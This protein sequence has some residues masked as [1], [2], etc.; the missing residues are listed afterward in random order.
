MSRNKKSRK[1]RSL[2][3]STKTMFSNRK[4]SMDS[5]RQTSFSLDSK[6]FTASLRN[7]KK[8]KSS[9]SSFN[10]I[11]GDSRAKFLEVV[12][13]GSGECS[14]NNLQSSTNSNGELSINN[15]V[16]SNNVSV[17]DAGESK[18]HKNSDVSNTLI[19]SHEPQYSLKTIVHP[20]D[21]KK[22][23]DIKLEIP[24]PNE[25][26]PNG[27]CLNDENDRKVSN[28]GIL[29]TFLSAAQHLIPRNLDNTFSD[30]IST[31]FHK[32]GPVLKAPIFNHSS[33]S[34]LQNLDFL[35]STTP[36]VSDTLSLRSQNSINFNSN[37]P[38]YQYEESA[39]Q[40]EFLLSDNHGERTQSLSP[41]IVTD[42]HLSIEDV[43]FKP[44]K[45]QS[46]VLTFGNGDLTLDKLENDKDN[47]ELS[48]NLK[49]T[50][51][52][53]KHISISENMFSKDKCMNMEPKNG[54]NAYISSPEY[55]NEIKPKSS[56]PS[57]VL[58]PTFTAVP[59]APEDSVG[60]TNG[61]RPRGKSLSKNCLPKRSLSPRVRLL[62]NHSLRS[63][64]SG[65]VRNQSND[66]NVL[67]FKDQ[68]VEGISPFEY[69]ANYPPPIKLK[70]ISFASEKKNKEFQQLIRDLGLNIT[71]Q[72]LTEFNCA[73]SKDIL[74][75]GK[76]YISEEHI[77]FYSNIL[78]WV[79]TI[80]VQFKEI[81]Q[82]E[83]KNT[84]GIF[85]NA[86]L[87]HTLHTKYVF[88][89]FIS[90]DS[91][92]E[93]ITN[94]WNQ[95]IST[96]TN[97]ESEDDKYE[98]YN[99]SA[100]EVRSEEKRLSNNIDSGDESDI[101]FSDPEDTDIDSDEMTSGDDLG[102]DGTLSSYSQL[103]D[104]ASLY[105]NYSTLG[106]SIHPPT[107]PNYK[108]SS[109]ERLVGE[110][111]FNAPLGKII[112][113]LFGDDV[114][115]ITGV[116]A[117][118]KNYDISEISSIL[119]PHRREYNYT[120]PISGSI[121]P[122]KTRCFITEILEDY[123]LENYVKVVQISKTPDIP[124]GNSFLVKTIFLLYWAENNHT[125]LKVYASVEWIGKSWIKN[126]I[127][128][129][130]F[131]GVTAT[132]TFLI[133]EVKKQ[134][135]FFKK[136]K[137]AIPEKDVEDKY[138]S[139]LPKMG[140]KEHSPTSNNY[141]NQAGDI[142]ISDD[143]NFLAP[144]G[145]IFQILFG[146]DISYIKQIIE[147]QKNIDISE[148]PKF[149]NNTRSYSYTKPLNGPIGPKQTKCLIVEII[150]KKDIDSCII[151][152]QI[153]RTPDVPSGGAFE[154]QT[155]FFFSWGKNNSTD[156]L[157][158][159]NI[160]W[161][162]KSWIKSAIEKGSTEG[163]RTSIG[164]MVQRIKDIISNANVEKKPSLQKNLKNKQRRSK[165]PNTEE[166]ISPDNKTALQNVLAK[167]FELF[168]F[169]NITLLRGM[170]LSF[171][172]CLL[173]LIFKIS[174]SRDTIT[175]T[176]SGTLLMKGQEYY[177]IP[178]MNTLYKVYEDE[179]QNRPYDNIVT[180]S[181]FNIWD[182][183]DNRGE[184]RNFRK[185]IAGLQHVKQEIEQSILITELQLEDMKKRLNSL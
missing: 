76:M 142:I 181:E 17:N 135:D 78:G 131:D 52:S 5:K 160:N 98:E 47:I 29:S 106:P 74:I 99:D 185:N 134:L 45:C 3:E 66:D 182:W 109:Q 72:L 105:P 81:V 108:P 49:V 13:D 37:I 44:L 107:S 24:I 25:G 32:N 148:I 167:G 16:L 140:P 21:S 175:I 36:N 115:F 9:D 97:E 116:I 63:A 157:V 101:D 117:A 165:I 159:T 38:R 158:V 153:T 166:S 145:T 177:F 46:S 136:P 80:T 7:K 54:D 11:F 141:E 8:G 35:L 67:K 178:S 42:S 15:M 173:I 30:N 172:I 31:T 171:C 86:I 183:I 126:V 18:T 91:V 152:K 92:F 103:T 28:T 82:I 127:E 41:H 88:A 83:K 114:S 84:A 70:N 102:N 124:S 104:K 23:K 129:G 6:S 61:K 163:Q 147:S 68:S 22:N 161:S 40:P 138:I 85:P 73:L 53:D 71:G 2:S 20:G 162:A 26:S 125:K 137:V 149:N 113:I 59:F 51:K 87:I 62:T 19:Q 100:I 180:Q 12:P 34:F 93:F 89:S 176:N 50:P 169:L 150:E 174:N 184:T 65:R 57:Q 168:R 164:L 33:S 143:I 64:V 139:L 48:E 10:K 77:F 179:I 130:T 111:I 155:R 56:S 4:H 123:D 119:V 90:R 121:G 79:S 144:L 43:T 39:D 151:V 112:N 118:Q 14:H 133:D 94:V 154:V 132:T 170:I 156:L 1:L 146:D 122:N 69:H 60:D 95:I 27:E 110:T 120:K 128:K 55:L 58:C 75:Q 96:E